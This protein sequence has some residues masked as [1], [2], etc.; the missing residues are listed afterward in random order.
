MSHAI[1]ALVLNGS[2]DGEAAGRWDLVPVALGG[3]LTLFHVTHYYTA[4]WQERLGVTGHF[5]FRSSAGLVFT[6]ENVVRVVAADLVG[7]PDP[8][9]ALVATEYFAGVGD[10]AAAV[11]EH[12]GSI[13]QVAT[14]NDALRVLGVVAAAGLDEFDTVGLAAHRS[15]PDYL[16]RY[17]DLCDE[18]GV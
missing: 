13:R 1:T 7:R 11:C 5:E 16:D 17:E 18:L 9:F 12:G 6:T 3:G 4:Y 10:Q 14:I 2:H 15:T 8:T